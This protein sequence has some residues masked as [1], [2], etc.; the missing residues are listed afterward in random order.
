MTQSEWIF[1]DIE[2]D[3]LRTFDQA[4]QRS[5]ENIEKLKYCPLQTD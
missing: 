4:T 3:S 1:F 2:I 5:I